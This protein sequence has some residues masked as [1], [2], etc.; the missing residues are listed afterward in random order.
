MSVVR[1]VAST[2]PSMFELLPAVY[3][4]PARFEP[5]RVDESGMAQADSWVTAD[6]MVEEGVTD[7]RVRA[8]Q[9]ALA[10]ARHDPGPV[11]G[12]YGPRT[13]DAVRAFQRQRGLVVDGIIGPQ[14]MGELTSPFLRRF[15]DGLEGVLGPVEETLDNLAAYLSVSTAPDG[16]LDWLAWLVGA[17]LMEGWNRAHRLRAV[18]EA[19]VL[20]RSRGTVPGIAAVVAL[21]LGL[22][23]DD[24]EVR[25]GGE[26]SWDL[27]P[28]AD[29]PVTPQPTVTVTLPQGS[30]TV[31]G[32]ELTRLEHVLADSLPVG[33]VVSFRIRGVPGTATLPPLPP[34]PPPPDPEPVP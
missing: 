32:H 10:D 17:D 7:E 4:D 3:R 27:D 24:V 12:V 6:H 31:G 26:T 29:L 9:Q 16:F 21:Q 30:A 18:S 23:A 2:R 5:R 13:V 1:G 15:L 34:L 20:H 22:H 28:D 19:L 8:L 11:D 25:D 14:T 33:F